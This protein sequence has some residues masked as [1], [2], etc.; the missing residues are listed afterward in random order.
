MFKVHVVAVTALFE[1]LLC[2]TA[3]AQTG[4]LRITSVSVQPSQAQSGQTVAVNFTVRN[5]GPGQGQ[6]TFM[7]IFVNFVEEYS[8]S[9]LWNFGGTGGTISFS[10]NVSVPVVPPGTFIAY[11]VEVNISDVGNFPVGNQESAFVTVAGPDLPDLTCFTPTGWSG[12][13]VVSNVSGTTVS[14]P[15]IPAG[16]QIFIDAAWINQGGAMPGPGGIPIELRLNGG[17]LAGFPQPYAP[18]GAGEGA[19]FL[20]R[21]IGILSPGSYT[22]EMELD[23]GDL[24]VDES[25]NGNNTCSISFMIEDDN[26]FGPADCDQDGDVDLDDYSEFQ[27]CHLGPA[28]GA[29]GCGCFDLDD[30]ESVD[31]ADFTEFMVLF[32]GSGIGACC[33]PGTLSCSATTETDCINGGGFFEGNGTVCDGGACPAEYSNTAASVLFFQPGAGVEVADDMN[34]S[35]NARDLILYQLDVAGLGGTAFDAAIQLHSGCPGDGGS[36]IPGTDTLVTG[37][38]NDGFVRTITVSLPSPVTIPG[39]VWMGVT[40]ND[41]NAVWMIGEQSEIGS[42][43]NEFGINQPPWICSAAFQGGDPYAG[44]VAGLQCVVDE[45]VAREVAF[46][47]AVVAIN[48]TGGSVWGEAASVMIEP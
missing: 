8:E 33:D 41:S 28:A 46:T 25:N 20:D 11:E 38:P 27:T 22:L 26:S 37:I 3:V 16:N 45:Q 19:G 32:T 48:P 13:L 21:P 5:F 44:F 7:E 10:R 39:T 29:Q 31:L 6:M 36:P 30:S 35:G 14:V 24:F 1:F 2:G 43:V 40:F 47:K 18:L 23:K 4:D 42:T 9:G 34:L 15:V 17:V 12:P